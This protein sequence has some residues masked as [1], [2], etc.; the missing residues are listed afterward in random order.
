MK[1]K[2]INF[3]NKITGRFTFFM[4][5]IICLF[6]ILFIKLFFVMVVDY[7]KN[8]LGLAKLTSN[9]VTLGSSPRGRIYDRNYNIIV[10]NKAINTIVYKKEKKVSIKEMIDLA[11]EVAPHLKLDVTKLT[12]RAK[13]EFF[14]A[15]Y[16]DLCNEKI[17]NEEKKLLKERKLT[18]QDIEELKIERITD[19]ELKEFSSDDF[20]AAYLFYLMNRGYAYEEKVIK[21]DVSDE[22][23]A[24]ISENNEKFPGFSTRVDWER[25]YPYGDTLKSILGTVSTASQGIP[26]EEKDEYLEAGYSL[27]EQVGLSYIE[28]QYEKYLRGKK[29]VYEVIN[30]H[31]LKL[32]EPGKRGNDIVLSIDINLQI[33]IEKIIEEQMRRA[34]GEPNTEYYDHSSVIIQEPN[35]GEILAIASK[36]IVN[37]EIVDN[38]TSMLISPITPGSVVKG[39]SML[40]GYDTGVIKAGEY[41][42]DECVKISGAPEKCSYVTLGKIDDIVAMAK[43]SNVYQ[44]KTA[45]RVN[46]QEYSKNMKLNFNQ[47]AFDT[48]RNM[49]HS[50]GLGVKTG[51]DLPIESS[52]YTSKDKNAGNLLDFVMGQYETYTPIQ[53]S[54]YVSTI[55]NG[56]SRIAPHLL[57]EVHEAT[58]S[59]K[60]G[61]LLFSVEKEVLNKI[62]VKSEHLNRVKEGF[63]AVMHMSDG[64]GR[65]YIDDKLNAA[66]KTGTSQSF[67]DTNNDGI[68]DTETI[69]SSFVGYAPADNPKMSIVVT[70]P[71][72]S[73]PNSTTDFASL[74][75]LRITKAVTNKYYEMYGG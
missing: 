67:L 38:V 71:N 18:N 45:I 59:E 8:K 31:E 58:D 20:E 66:G 32:V 21:S 6:I 51:I 63:Y 26:A 65:G 61:K 30:S 28:K 23:F 34:K 68:I 48:Y 25:I 74:V 52:G 50:F 43:S 27:N 73:H 16:P 64:Y 13:K 41:L 7:K 33:A 40:V 15:K 39:A 2:S 75:T 37:G 44:F 53:L 29:A 69:T 46:G 55:A 72:S 60:I 9:Y 10:D 24:Y 42:V 17:T 19:L 1:G 56:G 57:K 54:Q 3:D 22:E 4:F 12:L 11:Y 62:N 35:T 49:Y 36:K 14:L 47:K 70:S 5:I